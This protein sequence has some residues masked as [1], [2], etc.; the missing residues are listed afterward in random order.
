MRD[1]AGPDDEHAPAL[2]VDAGD[3]VVLLGHAQTPIEASWTPLRSSRTATSAPPATSAIRYIPGPIDLDPE[4]LER[5]AVQRRERRRD[6]AR[7]L[8]EPGAGGQP[9]EEPE[10]RL[11]AARPVHRADPAG[12]EAELEHALELRGLLGGKLTLA[13]PRSTSAASRAR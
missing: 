7:R 3:V 1:A 10:R 2:E 9:P 12:L 11:L 5:P 8:G 13:R 6:R 4:R